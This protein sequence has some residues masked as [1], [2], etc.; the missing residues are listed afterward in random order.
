MIKEYETEG[1]K[2]EYDIVGIGNA[3][4]DVLAMVDDE[5]LKR[6]KL[7]KGAMTL[8]DAEPAETLYQKLGQCAECSGGSVANS[9]AGLA[10]LGAK[11]A[12]MGRVHDD[13]LGHIFRHDM[14]SVGVDF[15]TPS[16]TS[17]KPTARCLVCVTPDGQRTMNTFIGA[18]A[19]MEPSDIDVSR[20][21]KSGMVYVEG[22]LWDPPAAKE[23]IVTALK[24]AR[25]SDHKV[26]F[27]L[28][29]T[30][31][32]DRHRVDFLDL[33]RH[34]IDVVFSNEAEALSLAETTD[35]AVAEKLL[36]TMA[37]IAVITR[38]EKPAIIW[39]GGK[40]YEVAGEKVLNVVDTTGAGDL[41]AAGFLY[42]LTRGWNI[43]ACAKLGHRCASEIIQQI[44]AR[45]LRPLKRLVA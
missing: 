5:F 15:D 14:R 11:V 18:C 43:E 38:S 41:F 2:L 16:A 12:F 24:A 7:N 29:D 31:C 6:E 32:V 42:G 23:A 37:D 28:S 8:I 35:I 10:S 20:I 36:S 21:T 33:I 13:Q 26:A 30:F 25:D 45:A 34:Y 3:I 39:H 1:K 17:G 22:Y 27:S 19:E 44:G 4:V 40:R 9:M